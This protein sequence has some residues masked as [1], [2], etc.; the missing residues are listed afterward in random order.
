[1]QN[2]TVIILGVFLFEWHKFDDYSNEGYTKVD[3]IAHT[4]IQAKLFR[5][6]RKTL[7]LCFMHF[8]HMFFFPT[9]G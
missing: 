3:Q 5:R 7:E 8:Q 4:N 1:M 9:I 2:R 6:G